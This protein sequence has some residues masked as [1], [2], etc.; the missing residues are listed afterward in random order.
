MESSRTRN[1]ML[2][3]AHYAHYVTF[4]QTGAIAR[5]TL[6]RPEKLNAIDY[7]VGGELYEAFER[8]ERPE[9]PRDRAGGGRPGVLRWRRAGARADRRTSSCR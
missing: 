9:H 1:A 3:D 2:S 4:E 8:C 5:I 7:Q 6:N